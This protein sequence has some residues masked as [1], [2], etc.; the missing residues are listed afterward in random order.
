MQTQIEI[1]RICCCFDRKIEK[2][3]FDKEKHNRKLKNR[4]RLSLPGGSLFKIHICDFVLKLKIN[5]KRNL[6]E[7]FKGKK[8]REKKLRTKG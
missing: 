1:T 6:S 5:L 3:T 7:N 8:K 2:K 4:H